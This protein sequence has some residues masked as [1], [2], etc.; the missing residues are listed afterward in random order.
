MSF[1]RYFFSLPGYFFGLP[2]AYMS[3][4]G[5]LTGGPLTTDTKINALADRTL[6]KGLPV[7]IH[8]NRSDGGHWA[9]RDGIIEGTSGGYPLQL[10]GRRPLG[11]HRRRTF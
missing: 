7:D 3:H 8:F 5:S 4:T 11:R 1:D 9:D 2:V 10:V 6:L